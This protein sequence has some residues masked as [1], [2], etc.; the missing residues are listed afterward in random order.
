MG[1]GGEAGSL[2]VAAACGEESQAEAEADNTGQDEEEEEEGGSCR[3]VEGAES[4]SVAPHRGEEWEGRTEG[5]SPLD[6][7]FTVCKRTALNRTEV[8]V[9]ETRGVRGVAA[10]TLAEEGREVDV[11]ISGPTSSSFTGLPRTLTVSASIKDDVVVVVLLT[12]RVFN[13]MVVEKTSP[14]SPLVETGSVVLS[15]LFGPNPLKTPSVSELEG[16]EAEEV[17]VNSSVVVVVE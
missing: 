10:S 11:W 5:R 15:P 3:Q 2:L 7:G 8:V 1:V 13:V 17:E 6:T 16:E 14:P 9:Y 4:G 12:S